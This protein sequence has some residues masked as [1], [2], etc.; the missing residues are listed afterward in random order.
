MLEIERFLR[1]KVHFAEGAST[2]KAGLQ[3]FIAEDQN[4]EIIIVDEIDEM[5]TK[6]Q[7][8]LL[9]MMQRGEFTNTKVRNTKNFCNVK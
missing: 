9:T 8:G 7:E 4:K 6:D 1:S 3:K 2:P 5:A